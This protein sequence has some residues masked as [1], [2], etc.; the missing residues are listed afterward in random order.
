MTLLLSI[1]IACLPTRYIDKSH[2]FSTRYAVI[3]THFSMITLLIWNQIES[4]TSSATFSWISQEVHFFD[5]NTRY[6]EGVAFYA[7]RFEHC[8]DD[9]LTD[10]VLDATPGESSQ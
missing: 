3:V 8:Y 10:F 7:K 2:T 5:H 9:D 6:A 4:Y 1:I